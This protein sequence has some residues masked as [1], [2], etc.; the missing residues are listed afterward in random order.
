[1]ARSPNSVWRRT[2]C[3][4]RYIE[5]E[6]IS[7]RE[8]VKLSGRSLST[9]TRWATEDKW[10]E[11]RDQFQAG[12][13]E[14]TYAKAV[15]KASEKLSDELSD[16]SIA[17]YES[18]KEMRDYV[19]DIIKRRR[20]HL[21][22]IKHLDFNEWSREVKTKHAPADLNHLSITL[23]RA[24]DGI[25]AALGLPYHVNVNTAYKKLESE[26]Y[27]V[28]NPDEEELD[29]DRD[30]VTVDVNVQSSTD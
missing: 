13:K 30:I 27:M 29:G 16:I 2:T 6:Q 12:L 10:K 28:V 24:T 20:S 18:H 5:G 26:G 9:L 25:S 14:A 17:N 4:K 22:E 1:M 11:S 15:E 3:A 7:I 19:L 23:S 8:L 21:E